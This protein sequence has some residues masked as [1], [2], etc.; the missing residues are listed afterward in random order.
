M[1]LWSKIFGKKKVDESKLTLADYLNSLPPIYSESDISVLES[2]VFRAGCACI[3][4][5]IRKV[6]AQH[7]RMDGNDP[8]PVND[9]ISFVLNNPNP[10]MTQSDFFEKITWRYLTQDNAFVYP[11]YENGELAA[12]YPLE[13]TNFKF[14]EYKDNPDTHIQFWFGN[15]L[16][17]Y[18]VI[19]PYGAIIHLRRNFTRNEYAGGNKEGKFDDTG[20]KEV[21]DLNSKLTSG[22]SKQVKLAS[23]V[24]M[25]LKLQ[26]TYKIE[27]EI[28]AVKDFEKKLIAN[29]SGI[30]PIG[31]DSELDVL[32]KSVNF[33][34]TDLLKFI[35]EKQLRP[36]GVSVAIMSGNYKKE[37]YEAFYQSALEPIIITFAQAFTKALF[38]KRELGFGNKIEFYPEELIFLNTSQKIEL[39]RLLGDCGALY[40]NEARSMVGLRPMAE[41]K[42]KR[43]QSLN[44][45]NAQNAS[46]YQVG[47]D[48]NKE[49]SDKEEDDKKDN[50]QK[51]V[52]KTGEKNE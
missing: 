12:L 2:D 34:S 25:A 22:L 29:E 38:T 39:I 18:E 9:A 48:K 8:I 42:G 35:D 15:G 31:I 33:I 3:C 21:V 5:E 40:M 47:E 16:N 11:L 24:Q 6:H 30:I 45:I 49:K 10:L 14:V 37:E 4:R 17:R 19:L 28:K 7:I 23:A 13:P 51:D 50:L 1:G 41:L 43:M 27:E 52:N 20:L 36:L 44:Y 46:K 26:S 32:N